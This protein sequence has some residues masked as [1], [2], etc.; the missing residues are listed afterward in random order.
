M[1]HSALSVQKSG[2]RNRNAMSDVQVWL[3]KLKSDDS[4]AAQQIWEC[5]FSQLVRLAHRRLGELPRRSVDEEDVALSAMNSFIQGARANR[6]PR[7]ND[8]NDLW[9]LLVTITARKANAQRRRHFA[10]RRASGAVRGESVFEGGADSQRGDGIAGIQ[11][12]EPSPEFAAEVAEQCQALFDK[13]NDPLLREIAG[14][15]MEGFTN[16]EIAQKLGRTVRTIERKLSLI[17][18]CWSTGEGQP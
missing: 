17:R 18:D 10:A 4:E 9:R 15:K 13:L 7:L 12:R 6:F 5:Y 3:E 11:D 1:V 14:W 8:E 16:E 2:P